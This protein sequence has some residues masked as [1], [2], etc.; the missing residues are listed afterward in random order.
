[1]T[2]EAVPRRTRL[3]CNTCKRETHHV[4]KG[5]HRR[6]YDEDEGHYWERTYYN[7]L[8]CAGC[9]TG[10][11][12]IA[13]TCSGMGDQEG[14]VYDRTYAPP[15]TTSALAIRRFQQIPEPVKAIYEEVIHAFNSGL[16]LL[17]AA[18]L[19]AL[20]EGICED[21]KID[22]RKLGEKIDGLQAYMHVGIVRNLHGF[23]FMGD[24]ALHKLK[25]PEIGDLR[26]AIE[27]SQDLLNYLYDLDYKSRQLLKDTPT[28]MNRPGSSQ[29]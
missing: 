5:E 13:W 28:N 27:V 17:C 3:F 16:R 11:L 10:S 29:Q 19:R 20:I 21:K 9:D 6:N 2:A 14:Q 22:G 12:E 1:M 18:G 25:A 4:L 8:V 26:I 24:P 23:R 7:L 15:R